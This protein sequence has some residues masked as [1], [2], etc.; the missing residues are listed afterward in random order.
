MFIS[1]GLVENS[2]PG[3]MLYVVR[4]VAHKVQVVLIPA[5]EKPSYQLKLANDRMEDLAKAPA[6][7]LVPTLNELQ[8]N[9]SEAARD[10]SR[11]D[12]TT[13]SPVMIK[14]IVD[15]AKKLEENKQKVESLGVVIGEKETN[16]LQEALRK[17]TEDLI[18]DLDLRALS[19]EKQ[20]VLVSM[21]DLF[22]QGKY[23]EALELYLVNQ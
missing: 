7:N 17:V 20:Q 5:Q 21:K 4:R 19:P 8:A 15:A 16:E 13:S 18:K 12:A 1:Y 3:D 22:I 11:I 10:L 9:I 14:K 6:R 2:L 23:A